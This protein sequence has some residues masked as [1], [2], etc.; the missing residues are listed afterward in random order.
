MDTDRRE[1]RRDGELCAIEPQVFDLLEFL[2]RNRDR[3]VTRDD[4]LSAVWNGRIVSE[5]TLTSRINSARTAIGDNGQDQR[6]IRTAL[7]K[8]IRFVGN[9]REGIEA[10]V[11]DRAATENPPLPL[12]DRPSIAVL[13]FINLSGDPEQDYFADGIVEDIITALSRFRQLFVIARN[14]SFTYKGRAVDVRM[15]GRELGVRYVLE[16]SVRK[17]ANR[18]R[19]TGQ[20]IDASSGAHIWSDRFEGGLDDIFDLQDRVTESVVGGIATRLN[21]A[22]IARAKRKPT[23]S[24]DAYD[25]YLRGMANVNPEPYP[26]RMQKRP[27]AARCGC[28][29]ARLSSTLIL[30]ALM[31][32]Q[33]GATYFASRAPGRPI[34]NKRRP[35]SR[36]WSGRRSNRGRMMQSPSAG[37]GMR[38]RMWSAT[39]R[40]GCA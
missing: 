37:Q 39:M 10:T 33:L 28:F 12:P 23:E 19:I 18:V 20:L 3:V 35:R 8:G 13:P 14:S 21:E 40:Q 16:G 30:P 4:L 34:G 2:I 9:V 11:A 26:L 32:L 6:L 22:E 1:L 27:A 5:A 17:S 25:Y 38:L 15:V 24:L 7:R 31:P 36:D 29:T